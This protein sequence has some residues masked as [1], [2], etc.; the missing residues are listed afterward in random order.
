LTASIETT[1]ASL[2]DGGTVSVQGS[3]SGISNLQQRSD[4]WLL[5]GCVVAGTFVLGPIGLVFIIVAFVLLKR[6]QQRGEAI[7]PWAV[8]LIATYC[9]I[10]GGLNFM[11]WGLDLFWAHDTVA[12]S[13]FLNGFGK[14]FDGGYYVNYNLHAMGGTAFPGEKALEIGGVL[15][16]FP[17][18]V[19]AAWGFLKMKRWG[20]QFMIITSWMYCLML[21]C[22]FADLS[23][24][25]MARFGDSIT[26]VT[27]YW[28][29][30]V[31]YMTPFIMLPYLHTMNRHQFTD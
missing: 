24:T 18:R 19:I 10:D 9:M 15:F 27:G 17:M 5:A 13:T 3:G 23:M 30:N 31:F 16:L 12:G 11:G 22:Y 25:F 28:A 8:T 26:G 4:R 7:R 29:F 21:I 6:A 20:H 1:A 2:R 14:L